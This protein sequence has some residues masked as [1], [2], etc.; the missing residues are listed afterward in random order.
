MIY[1]VGSYSVA[2]IVC[3]LCKRYGKGGIITGFILSN[4]AITFY[5][6]GSSQVLINLYEILIAGGLFMFMPAKK[7]KQ[8]KNE[9]LLLLDR[10]RIGQIAKTVRPSG[11]GCLKIWC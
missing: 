2:A 5:V 11:T 9:I 7:L 3:S 1:S 8:M 4:A 10:A 6:N